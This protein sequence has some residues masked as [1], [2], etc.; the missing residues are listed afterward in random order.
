M[1]YCLLERELYSDDNVHYSSSLMF[2]Y[3]ML[4][5]NDKE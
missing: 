4:T 2:M 3:C 1:Y 5:V